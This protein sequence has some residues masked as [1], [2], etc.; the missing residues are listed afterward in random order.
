MD[1]A[2]NIALVHDTEQAATLLQPLRLRLVELLQTPE[3][4][5][6]VARKVGL[7]R[8]VVN[9]HLRQLEAHGLLELVEERRQGSRTERVLKASARS[10][11]IG[12]DALGALAADPARVA[13]RFSAS[14][15]L[16]VA[17]RIIQQVGAAMAK[18]EAQRKRIATLTLLTQVRFRS[19]SERNDFAEELAGAIAGLVSKYNDESAPGGRRFELAL[20]VY[21]ASAAAPAFSPV[22]SEE[23]K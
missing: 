22:G 19:A 15:L 3:T 18:A 20:G 14:Y 1:T 21:P 8:Q 10:Y 13:D 6:G 12:P 16:A 23:G 11:L 4:A 9:Y 5:A 17:A 2:A 7:P